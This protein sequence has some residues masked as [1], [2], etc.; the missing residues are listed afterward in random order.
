VRRLLDQ[1]EAERP[2]CTLWLAP[3]CELAAGFQFDR[4]TPLIDLELGPPRSA[5]GAPPQGGNPSGPA[6]PDPRRSLG[7]SGPW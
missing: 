5:V 1:I 7:R 3:L 4:I 2:E 6:E